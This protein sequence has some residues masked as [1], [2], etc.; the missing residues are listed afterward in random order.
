MTKDIGPLI[1]KKRKENIRV[2]HTWSETAKTK[3]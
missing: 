2:K 3:T 1:K